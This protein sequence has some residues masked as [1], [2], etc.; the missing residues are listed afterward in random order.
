MWYIIHT[1]FWVWL[2][3]LIHTL[4]YVDETLICWHHFLPAMKIHLRLTLFNQIWF[5]MSQRIYVAKFSMNCNIKICIH[6]IYL[7]ATKTYLG[8]GIW[9]KFL[10]GVIQ[11][12]IIYFEGATAFLTFLW[13]FVLSFWQTN[14][15]QNDVI[16]G[17]WTLYIIVMKKPFNKLT[18]K[19]A[20]YLNMDINS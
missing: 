5:I 16:L 15:K 20:C 10:N 8:F 6:T 7:H 4:F 17:C 2:I 18:K 13:F 19:K 9:N 11:I 12:F 1:K 3:Y 14:R